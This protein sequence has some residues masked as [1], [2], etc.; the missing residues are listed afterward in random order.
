MQAHKR[1][2][3]K[4][5]LRVMNISIIGSE[6]VIV[7]YDTSFPSRAI[8]IDTES[9]VISQSRTH[10]LISLSFVSFSHYLEQVVSLYLHFIFY[11][12]ISILSFE[13]VL[14]QLSN[15]IYSSSL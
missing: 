6:G 13:L 5:S 11:V 10:L 15:S 9:S 3:G 8:R 12:Y 14:C 2:D 1:G 4:I 7:A